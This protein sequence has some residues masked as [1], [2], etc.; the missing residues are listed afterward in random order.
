MV[1]ILVYTR[2][3][4]L[5]TQIHDPSWPGIRISQCM[6]L[7]DLFAHLYASSFG[8]APHETELTGLKKSI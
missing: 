7:H 3:R 6:W 1:T 4:M 2:D 8:V 5:G